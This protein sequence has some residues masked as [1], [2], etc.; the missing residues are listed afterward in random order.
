MWYIFVV[1]FLGWEWDVS[2]RFSEV[3]GPNFI[4]KLGEDIQRSPTLSNFVL[5]FCYLAPFQNAGVSEAGVVEFRTKWGAGQL[6]F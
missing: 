5:E 2:G 3:R 6:W 4:F 1:Q